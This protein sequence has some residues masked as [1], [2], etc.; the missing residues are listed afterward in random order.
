MPRASQNV[1]SHAL[2]AARN[3]VDTVYM[4]PFPFYS[5]SFLPYFSLNTTLLPSRFIECLPSPFL[6]PYT[7]FLFHL[8]SFYTTSLSIQ[9]SPFL[10][11]RVFYVPIPLSIHVFSVFFLNIIFKD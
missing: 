9:Q 2:P 6:S 1:V 3:S 7:S 11:Y 4:S 8:V 10:F 5:V